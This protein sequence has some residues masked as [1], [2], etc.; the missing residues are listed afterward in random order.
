MGEISEEKVRNAV[1][2][3]RHPAIDRTLMELGILK[4]ITVEGDKVIITLAFPF[5]GIPIRELLVESVR[6]PVEEMGAKVEVKTTVMTAEELQAFLA[7]E[8]EAWGL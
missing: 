2:Q 4:D 6:E 7:M 5:P 1:A 3:V 8:Q